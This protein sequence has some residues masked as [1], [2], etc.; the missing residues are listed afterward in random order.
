[1]QQQPIQQDPAQDRFVDLSV[2]VSYGLPQLGE[3]RMIFFFFLK[4][5]IITSMY[6]FTEINT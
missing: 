1:M 3:R 5:E 2:D 6:L 4:I